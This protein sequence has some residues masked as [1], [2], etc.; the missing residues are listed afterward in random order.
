VPAPGMGL[1]PAVST[2]HAILNRL[3]PSAT[4]MIR[5]DH[6]RVLAV[7]H[8]YHIDA[9]P[10]AKRAL[11]SAICLALEVHARI[12]EEI[13]YPA[14]RETETSLVEEQLEPEHE[15]MRRLIAALRV[16]APTRDQYDAT[17]MELMRVVMHHVA[18]EETILLTLAESVM[19]DRLQTLGRQM[20]I[21][22]LQLKVPQMAKSRNV[23]VLGGALLVGALLG[24]RRLRRHA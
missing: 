14:L 7:F 19:G 20:A 24:G 18:D 17:F 23:W 12:E 4:E 9:S 11:V 13:F 21:R 2:M 8:R 16:M 5:A 22:R 15:E 10:R 3:S 6:T 1:A